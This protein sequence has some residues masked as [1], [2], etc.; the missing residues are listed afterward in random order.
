VDGA[1]LDQ[2]N[3]NAIGRRPH[4]P[5]CVFLIVYGVAK[6]AELA[7]W[8]RL[9]GDVAAMLDA[10]SGTV[11]GLLIAGKGT[12]L[13]L[14]AL[15]VLALIRRGAALLLAAL[16]GWTA[17]LALLTV[18]A[19]SKGD[20][21]RLLEHGVAFVAFAGLLVVTY[22]FGGA[23]RRHAD[24]AATKP[25]ETLRDVPDPGATRQDL[26]VRGASVTRQDLHVRRPEVTR[27]DLH[28]RRPPVPPQD[29]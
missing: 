24:P 8:S 26:P 5:V 1:V 12:E 21:G 15:A 18:V 10:G 29:R 22:V 25:H 23:R 27:Q 6:L 17:D 14:T 2:A 19:G 11:T 16:V 13:V 7:D 9:H 4:T 20:H 28:V 3:G